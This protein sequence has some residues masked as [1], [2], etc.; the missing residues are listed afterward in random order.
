VRIDPQRESHV[1]VSE[2]LGHFLDRN[3]TAKQHRGVRSLPDILPQ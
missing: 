3:A 2:V 1:R